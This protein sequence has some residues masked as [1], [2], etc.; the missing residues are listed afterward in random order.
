ME[1]Y[2]NPHKKILQSHRILFVELISAL[3]LLVLAVSGTHVLITVPTAKTTFAT[4]TVRMILI[5]G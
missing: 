1:T 4:K 2:L 3:T 5:D